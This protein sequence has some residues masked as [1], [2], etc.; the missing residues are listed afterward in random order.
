MCNRNV[1]HT[2]ARV[3]DNLLGTVVGANPCAPDSLEV[4]DRG[5]RGVEEVACKEAR[6]VHTINIIS[7]RQY[8]VARCL[9]FCVDNVCYMRL[10]S[11]RAQASDV[12]RTQRTAPSMVHCLVTFR[13]NKNSQQ[14]ELA[15][16]ICIFLRGPV[17][18]LVVLRASSRTAVS[19]FTS[20]SPRQMPGNSPCTT[21]LPSPVNR[22][23]SS[24]HSTLHK[25]C[26]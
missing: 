16:D 6:T 8:L 19:R 15:T 1:S 4:N 20:D 17:F 7:Q 13:N 9:V 21:P 24:Y 2:Q 26:N 14:I 12:D 5:I 18:D 3:A 10:F 23:Q 22:S 11:L 25:E